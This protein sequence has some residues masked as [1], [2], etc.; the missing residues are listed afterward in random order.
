MAALGATAVKRAA[1]QLLSRFGVE[2]L[3][4]R[5][6][7]GYL[8]K[9]ADACVELEACFRGVVFDDLPACSGRAALLAQLQGTGVSEAMYLLRYLHRALPLNGDVCEFGIAQGATS[10][11]LANEIRDTA[12]TLWLFDSFAGLP[13]PGPQDVLIDDI[14]RLGAM[15]A[16]EGKMAEGPGLV[17]ERLRRIDISLSRVSIVA[18]F[19]AETIRTQPMPKLVCLAYVDLDLYQPIKTALNFLDARLSE[20]GYVIV[21]DYGHFSAGAQR[22]VDEFVAENSA[23]Y[24]LTLPPDFAGHFAIVQKTV[25]G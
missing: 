9:Y 7:N 22:A 2:V 14:Y 6:L 18:G 10:A 21:D 25:R 19:I 11:L 16:Y 13:R 15:Q 1:H 4:T 12:K 20:G 24:N 5:T 3:Q 17:L 8:D 23:R